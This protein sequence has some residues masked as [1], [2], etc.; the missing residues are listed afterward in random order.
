MLINKIN[1]ERSDLKNSVRN[2]CIQSKF[3]HVFG[4]DECQLPVWIPPSVLMQELKGLSRE[5]SS[6][7]REKCVDKNRQSALNSSASNNKKDT[8]GYN[9]RLKLFSTQ[10]NEVEQEIRYLVTQDPELTRKMSFLE[11]IPSISFISSITVVAETSGFALIK[12][13][14]QLS[15]YAGYDAVMKE[16]GT[17]RGKHG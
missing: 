4:S 11:S 2:R 13:A 10:I 8:S 7:I 6:I 3:A 16:S 15:S 17:Y 14:K 9:Q 5:R 12:S 1:N